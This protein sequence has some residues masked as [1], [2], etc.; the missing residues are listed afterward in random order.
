MA[1][2]L[3]HLPTGLYYTPSRDVAV[4]SKDGITRWRIKSNLSKTGKL[5]LTEAQ[6]GA[7]KNCG[8]FYDHTRCT[9]EGRAGREVAQTAFRPMFADEWKVEEV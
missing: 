8:T 9:W 2:R 6:A 1:Y 3:K 7:A 5:Y 4:R